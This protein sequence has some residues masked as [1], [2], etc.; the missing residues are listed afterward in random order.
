[1]VVR[2]T[3]DQTDQFSHTGV[4]VR[5]HEM[6]FVIGIRSNSPRFIQNFFYYSAV[7]SI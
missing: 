1:M 6:E 2:I 7:D 4:G 3:G 5:N